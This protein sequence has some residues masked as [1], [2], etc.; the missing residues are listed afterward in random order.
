MHIPSTSRR[1][2]ISTCSFALALALAACSSG[3][4]STPSTSVS[5][6][7]AAA[8]T[9]GTATGDVA[10]VTWYGGY[11][12]VITLDPVGIADYPEET[13]I[14]NMCEPLVRV[15]PDYSL[16]PGL[17]AKFGYADDTHYVIT[18]RQG[19]TFWDG[20]PMTAEDV[21]FSLRRNLDPRIAS[22]Y[23]GSFSAVEKIE[24]T[25]ADTVTVTLK[26]RSVAF[27]SAL[28]TL[29]GAVVA[30]AFAEKAGPGFG[31][32]PVGVMC[33]GPFQFVS[34]DGAASLVM[35]K[36]PGYW[37]PAKAARAQNWTFVYPADPSALANGLAS[38]GIDGALTLPSNVAASVQKSSAG[39]LYVGA[40]GSTPINVDLLFTSSTGH[41]GNADVRA[42]LSMALDRAGIAKAVFAGTA[43][44]LYKV[45]GPGTWGTAA[46]AYQ[47]AYRAAT[48]APDLAK[49]KSLISG[50]GIGSTPLRFAF[51]AGDAESS[52]IAT[53]VQQEAAGIGLTITLLGLPNQQYGALFVDPAARSAYDLILTK[54]YVELPEPLLLDQLL[55]GAT[56]NMNFSGYRDAAV[57][58]SIAKADR[59]ADPVERARLVLEIEAKL[60]AALPAIPIVAPRALVF[61][62]KRLTGSTL[63]FSYMS[64]P[65]AAAV[66]GK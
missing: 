18:V 41:A 2:A 23:S 38:G 6:A 51:P 56:G 60:A 45:A 34:Y 16:Q 59:T 63:T 11:R 19:V 12:P 9:T 47:P 32:P 53:V 26:Q 42:G 33:T 1:L 49:A 3:G 14:P 7:S 39:T 36:N 22:N 30:K 13:A 25:A 50:S 28:A 52:Q 44:P 55:G 27:T 46:A 20:T 64:S 57:E 43:D 24:A 4:S 29:A 40:E 15:A 10:S 58:D 5:G 48:A 62:N 37:D 54:N 17:A 8:L 35:K 65:W 31:T 66:G 21:A 61:E